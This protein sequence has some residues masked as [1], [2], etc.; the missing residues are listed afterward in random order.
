MGLKLVYLAVNQVTSC[1]FFECD[2]MGFSSSWGNHTFFIV[3][4]DYHS[5]KNKKSHNS[6]FIQD[7][8]SDLLLLVVPYQVEEKLQCS[9]RKECKMLKN[10]DDRGAESSKIENVHTSIKRLLSKID[11]TLSVVDAISS[12]VQKLRD[13]ELH[14]QLIELI[15]G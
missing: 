10:L 8:L 13:D 4:L 11:V 5:A 7:F 6:F 12:R 9:Y 15:E 2:Q 14:F 3:S 1:P